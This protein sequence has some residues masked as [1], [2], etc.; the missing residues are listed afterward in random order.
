M[1]SRLTTRVRRLLHDA[2]LPVY[3][4][5]Q[6]RLPITGLDVGRGIEPRRADL[7]AWALL[8]L[9]AIRRDQLRVP[10][11]IRYRDLVVVHTPRLLESLTRPE[12]LAHVFAVDSWDVPVDEVLHTVRLACGGTLAAARD[13]R[14]RGGP[15]LNLLGGFHHAFP[16]RAGGLCP[17]NDIAV[18]IAALREDGFTGRVVV[19]DLDAHPPDGTAACLATDPASWIGSISG[20]DWGPLDGPADEVCLPGADD[21][22]YLSALDGLLSRMPAAELAFVIAGG[23]VLAGDRMGALGLTPQGVRLRD[24][25]VA[26]ALSGTPAVWLPGG[27]YSDRAW[28]LLAGTGLALALGTDQELP[29]DADPLSD[30]FADVGR[31][32]DPARLRGDGDDEQWFTEDDVAEIL[33]LP[34]RK[35]VRLLDYYTAS[36]VE[37]GLFRY[38]LLE[39]VRRLGYSDLRVDLART[40]TGDRM[41]L[42]GTSGGEEHLLV[43]GVYERRE[44]PPPDGLV[45]DAPVVV[46]FVHWLTLRHPRGR[47]SEGRPPLPGQDAP[48]LGMAREAGE[49]LARMAERLE[50]AG[51]GVRPSWF[52]VAYAS[53]YHFRFV[54]PARQGRFEALIRDLAALPLLERTHAVAEGRVWLDGAPYAWEPDLMVAWREAPPWPED[55]AAVA[56]ERER[57]RFVLHDQGDGRTPPPVPTAP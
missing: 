47:F 21:D 27:G 56:A 24:L 4:A 42:H 17:V 35:P 50:L 2:E 37:Y 1:F 23:D 26:R 5:P 46:L 41:R 30:R 48:G 36:G 39:Q 25:A 13:A 3:Y 49:M 52:H 45:L 40:G 53:R 11:R 18:A 9:G 15:V 16:D 33:G 10:P 19:L 22:A 43:E 55:A 14:K 20:S 28:R 44:V 6:Y 31:R 12:D 34:G 29:P 57:A 7:A 8:E 38:G 32:L 54:D 51:V